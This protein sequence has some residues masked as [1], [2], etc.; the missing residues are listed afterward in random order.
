MALIQIIN[1]SFTYPGALAPV[2]KDVNLD[3]DTR[4]R[5]GL[6]G[7]NGRGKTTLLRLMSGELTGQGV[8]AASAR[9]EY[10]PKPVRDTARL[11]L[12]VARQ[13]IA[14]FEAWEAEM[15]RLAALATPEAMEA[16]G[17]LELTYAAN[18]G[19]VI[20]GAIAAE[21]G[22][23]GIAEEALGRPFD[24]LSGGEQVKLLLAAAFLR[25]N[26][27]LLIDEPTDHLD[28]EGRRRVAAWL[29]GKEGF[30]LVS[31]DRAF[32]DASIDHV[33]SINRADIELQRGNYTSWRQNREEQDDFERGQNK[34]LEKDIGRLTAAAART[35]RWSDQIEKSKKCRNQT[36]SK[37]PAAL[38][39]GYV[40]HQ[41]ARMM[42]RSKV[43][44][45]RREAEIEQKKQLL[46]NIEETEPL[47]FQNL[48]AH[49]QR[50]LL[51]EGLCYAYGGR[52]VLNL[53]R[54][55]VRAGER[56]AVT[57]ANGCGKST[58]LK[59]LAGALVPTSGTIQRLSGLQVS[60]VQQDVFAL[61]G[62][63]SACAAQNGVD[64]TL[65]ITLL[66]KLNFEREAF[67]REVGSYSAGQKKKVALALSLAKP[68][69]LLLWDEPLNYIDVLSR[70]QI[71]SAVLASN[72]TL[73][74]VE[75]DQAFIGAVATRV[76]RL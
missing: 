70:E 76:L 43:I 49:K 5:L 45:G 52:Q 21:A 60:V 47:A 20:D 15:R 64:E 19:Y 10:F 67:A 46:K 55:E 34:K 11:A 16:Y 56:I 69:H 71:E 65:F 62:S 18:D 50:T 41:A 73:V 33:L 1:L 29:A 61:A 14:P 2:F 30:I 9:F 32:L 75:H 22:R 72:P 28:A 3:L 17:E 27:F 63:L 58:L 35:E 37:G 7:R 40:G 74:F 12:A 25:K 36:Y 53:P 31:H 59:L 13:S 4:W 48:A 38:D 54:L 57:G 23:L 6:I 66:R 44:L 24:T 8:I 39:R 26:S 42:K 51:A 68:A